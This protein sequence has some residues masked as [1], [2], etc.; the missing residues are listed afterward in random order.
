MQTVCKHPLFANTLGGRAFS[1][2]N[3]L[4]TVCKHPLFANNKQTLQYCSLITLQYHWPRECREQPCRLQRLVETAPTMSG[5]RQVSMTGIGSV[6]DKSPNKQTVH[7]LFA[8]RRCLQTPWRSGFFSNKQQTNTNKH[9]FANSLRTLNKHRT[10]K[11]S[12]A[13]HRRTYE[14]VESKSTGNC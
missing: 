2:T 14:R 10:L 1:Q 6:F 9:L 7:K 5:Q 12:F 13:A 8:N 4:Q 11:K 3:G